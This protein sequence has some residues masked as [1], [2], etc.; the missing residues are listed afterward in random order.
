MKVETPHHPDGLYVHVPFCDGKCPYCAFYS[1][2]FSSG[3]AEDWIRAVLVEL[4]SERAAWPE[5]RPV[6]V[7]I[8]GGTPSLLSDDLWSRLSEA[9]HKA[10]DFSSVTEWTVESNPGSLTPA[11]LACWKKT[12]VN[13]ISLGVQA[14]DDDILRR[15]GRRNT[16]AQVRE[17]VAAIGAAGFDNWGLDLIACVPGVGPARWAATLDAALELHP[18][19]MS[20][21]ALTVEEG[22][23]LAREQA[24]GRFTPLSDGR[25]LA[26]L[27]MAEARLVKAGFTRYEISNYALPGCECRHNLAVWRGGDYLG[28]GPAAASHCGGRRWTNAAD[29]AAYGAAL[30]PSGARPALALPREVESLSTEAQAL[31]RL[32]FGLRTAEGVGLYELEHRYALPP[33]GAVLSQ[34]RSTLLQL[35]GIGVVVE[36]NGIWRLTA[37]GGEVADSVAVELMA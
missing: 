30:M 17:A 2:P 32:I 18:Q 25:Q 33:A 11:R 12:G 28:L 22:A 31:D 13:R 37:R 16:V 21:Y 26:R 1:V 10:F 8:G 6:T 5:L 27:A 34:W 23:K 15:L 3:G 24:A 29:V 36:A 35:A 7:Y 4:V 14:M 20:V 9:L 19:H